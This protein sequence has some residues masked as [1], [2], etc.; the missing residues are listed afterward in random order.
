MP[1]GKSKN[2]RGRDNKGDAFR[3]FE[4]GARRDAAKERALRRDAEKY[5]RQPRG[6]KGGK[7]E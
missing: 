5:G 3:E 1:K 4:Q 7:Q 2:Q 6:G